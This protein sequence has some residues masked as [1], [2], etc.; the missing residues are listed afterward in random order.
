MSSLFLGNTLSNLGYIVTGF[1][2]CL[3]C[4]KVRQAIPLRYAWLYVWMGIIG[5]GSFMFHATLLYY[6]Q[7]LDEIPMLFSNSQMLY[8]L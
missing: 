5:I 6:M 4:L 3:Q 1:Y 8:V 7:L 2:G